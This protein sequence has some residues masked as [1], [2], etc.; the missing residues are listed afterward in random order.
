MEGE[1]FRPLNSSHGLPSN[2]VR[3]ILDDGAGKLWF[4]TDLGLASLSLDLLP[5]VRPRSMPGW[6]LP[7]TGALLLLLILL[8]LLARRGP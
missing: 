8:L 4:V 6:L 3:Q 7:G 1:R 5:D 2:V